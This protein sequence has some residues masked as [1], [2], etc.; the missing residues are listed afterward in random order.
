MAS[1]RAERESSLVQARYR[2]EREAEQQ[3][4]LSKGAAASTASIATLC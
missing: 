4:Q 2:P 1:G 3:R